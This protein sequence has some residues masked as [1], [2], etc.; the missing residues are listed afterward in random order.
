MMSA[1]DTL[2]SQAFG[3]GNFKRVGVILQRTIIIV[4][5][6]CIP[7]SFIWGFSEQILIALQQDPIVSAKAG[8]F[9]RAMIP[10]LPAY[11]FFEA[12]KRWLQMQSVVMPIL[13]IVLV[14]AGLN[15]FITWLFVDGFGLGYTGAPIAIVV[16]YYLAVA[17][18]LGYVFWK[19]LHV[20]TWPGF[21]RD[22]WKE[23]PTYLYYGSFGMIM[24]CA[25]WWGFEIH[26]LLAGLMGT[27]PVAAQ[28]VILNTM[29]LIFMIPLG[30][31]IGVTTRVGNSLGAGDAQG[32]ARAAKVATVAIIISQCIIAVGFF[33]ARNS[34]GWVFTNEEEVVQT[35]AATLPIACAF[36]F[37]DGG[38]GVMSGAMRG[39]GKQKIGG[40]TNLMGYYVIGIP[41]AYFFGFH[42]EMGIR[43]LWI[44][45][46]ASSVTCFVVFVIVLTRADWE[47]EAMMAQKRSQLEDAGLHVPV[48]TDPSLTRVE[49]GKSSPPSSPPTERH[50]NGTRL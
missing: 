22:A 19:K 38:Q 25:E 44:G 47:H 40:F 16:T 1:Q 11:M 39:I 43:G 37:A 35:V 17:V 45:L 46:L 4:M 42:L 12:V 48:T 15:V 34:W 30:V 41:I 8:E 32:A 23:W 18:E 27:V 50:S 26:T 33:I 3:A 7:L 28:T 24:I 14:I 9:I 31:Q 36:M 5:L 20:Q 13:Y 49:E 21:S 6:M 10:S 29:Q 2:C